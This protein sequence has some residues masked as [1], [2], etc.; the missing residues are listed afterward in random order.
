MKGS[1][2]TPSAMNAG[3]ISRSF[4]SIPAGGIRSAIQAVEFMTKASAKLID[5]LEERER[6]LCRAASK[7]WAAPV[8]ALNDGQSV[9]TAAWP[10]FYPELQTEV[11]LSAHYMVTTHTVRNTIFFND[12]EF[13]KRAGVPDSWM[14]LFRRHLQWGNS[15]AYDMT[16]AGI[17]AVQLFGGFANGVSDSHVA[18]MRRF[19]PQIGRAL[20]GVTNGDLIN[21]TMREFSMAFMEWV[22]DEQLPAGAKAQYEGLK[23]KKEAAQPQQKAFVQREIDEMANNALWGWVDHPGRSEKELREMFTNIQMAMK[24]AYLE[25][26]VKPQLRDLRHRNS[27]TF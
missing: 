23:K 10:K 7:E 12:R 27:G 6:A 24:R 14:W 3:S 18:D 25:R 19:F 2:Y 11:L 8:I 15:E 1:R 16:K 4:I 21:L 13:L 26:Y 17:M 5:V 9:L 20:H 22:A